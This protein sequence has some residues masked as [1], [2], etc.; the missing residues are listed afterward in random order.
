[1]TYQLGSR[2]LRNLDGV[3]PDIVRAVKLA[4]KRTKQDF[5]IIDGG[6]LRSTADAKANAARGVGVTNS[7]HIKQ[8][9]T[10]YGHAVDL[11]AYRNGRPDW[12]TSYNERVVLYQ[13]IREAMLS[14]CDEIGLL[15]QHGAD[16]DGDGIL[17]ERGE[18]DWPHWQIPQKRA[19]IAALASAMAK[20]LA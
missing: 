13:P 6:G 8:S 7:L 9:S 2:S 14:A 16:W 11:V 3:H 19:R 18:W 17:G 10:G 15:I 1:M 12:G 5:C 4:I 20:R